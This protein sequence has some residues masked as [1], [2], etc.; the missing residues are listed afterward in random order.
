MI[1][2]FILWIKNNDFLLFMDSRIKRVSERDR[3]RESEW[4]SE[5]EIDK[6]SVMTSWLLLIKTPNNIQVIYLFG[7]SII[8]SIYYHFYY[9]MIPLQLLYWFALTSLWANNHPTTYIHTIY[10]VY[11]HLLPNP[12]SLISS[13][14]KVFV[15]GFSSNFSQILLNHIWLGHKDK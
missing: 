12:L 1:F 13:D 15:S 3:D 4:E 5:K 11:L 7:S 2:M 10:Y 9:S 14:H 8:L 6:E